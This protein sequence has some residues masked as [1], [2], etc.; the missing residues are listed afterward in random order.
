MEFHPVTTFVRH[1]WFEIGGF[2]TLAVSLWIAFG[3]LRHRLPRVLTR[4]GK[5]SATL[6]LLVLSGLCW[7][8]LYRFLRDDIPSAALNWMLGCLGTMLLAG[9]AF[10]LTRKQSPPRHRAPDRL[11][12]VVRKQGPPAKPTTPASSTS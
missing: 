5:Y 7:F 1:H 8:T 4:L 10:V 2:F 9:A 6:K 3:P 11:I 12:P